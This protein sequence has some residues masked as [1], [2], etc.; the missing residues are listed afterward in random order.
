MLIQVGE[1]E[2]L[3][4]EAELLAS[5]AR[6]AGVDVTFEEWKQ[7]VHVWHLYFHMLGAGREAIHRVG[8]FLRARTAAGAKA[9]A[10][11]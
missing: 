5:K 2:V 9:R 7:M 8:E 6:A 10:K 4:S 3:F 1:R 11:T